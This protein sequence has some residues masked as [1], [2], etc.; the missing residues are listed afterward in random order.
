MTTARVIAALSVF[1]LVQ[2]TLAGTKMQMNI[3]PTPPDCSGGPMI[4]LNSDAACFDIAG[5]SDCVALGVSPKSKVK[6]DGKLQLKGTMLAVKDNTGALV[7]TGPEGAADNYV[8]QMG[9]QT[10]TVDAVEIPYCSANQDVYVKVVI[11]GGKGKIKVDLKPV[12]VSL[13]V[14]TALR[15][16]HVALMTPRGGGNCLGDNSGPSL[17]ARLN[18]GT[19]NSGTG[20]LGVGGVAVE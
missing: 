6:L 14:G 19:C 7:T 16:N 4:C 17:T 3:V 20:V 9:L 2:S 18:D 13:A 15:V 8:L 5:N 11:T 1:V 12:F 10:C